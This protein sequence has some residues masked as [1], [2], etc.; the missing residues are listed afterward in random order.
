MYIVKI[1]N[2]GIE[3]EIHGRKAKL[4]DGSIVKGINVIDS[5]TFT[6]LPSN[7]GFSLINDYKTLVSVYNTRKK[8][9]EYFGRV[10]CSTPEM[11]SSGHITKN[12]VCESYFGFL[13]DS[14]QRYVAERNWT[15][16]ELWE[17][18][19]SVHN[20]QVEPERNFQLGEITVEDTND[21]LY[22]GIQRDDTWK[23]I[24]DKLLGKLGG[25]IR[26]R[27]V[28]GLIYIDHLVEIGERRATKIALSR[29]M[30]S[31]RK[32]NDPSAYIS[33]LIPLGA[34]FKDEDGNEREERLDIT[35]VNNGLDY[36]EDVDAREAYGIRVDYAYFDN[37]TT[38]LI[39]KAK[40]EALL[41]ENNRVKIKYSIT[42]VDLS[43]L[44]LDIDD[45]NVC[46]Y[47]PIV[48]PLLGIDDVARLV[49]KTIDVCDE[50]QST[51]EVGDAF[52]SL[53]DIQAEQTKV[54]LDLS[55]SVGRIESNYVSNNTLLTES[56][57]TSSLISQSE[58]GIMASV[59]ESYTKK[60][61]FEEQT[62]ITKS[63][64]SALSD[65]FNLSFSQIDERVNKVDGDLQ[66]KYNE[67][68]KYFTFDLNGL[69]IGE[70]DSPY[71][72]V[73]DNDD[74]TIWS[75]GIIVQEFKADGNSLIPS[76]TVTK[77]FNLLGLQ[78]AED[79]THINCDY[80]GGV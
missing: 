61:A 56:R 27:V 4:K 68:T 60:S 17:H 11:E 62:R 43:L 36:I 76:L 15:V 20:S 80:V 25:E 30:K 73:I 2:N 26:I 72:I 78:M 40:G 64:M 45:F 29:N 75:G 13:C 67:I 38:P 46:D 8:R 3:T 49:K 71:K 79:E 21:N 16:R 23:T 35:S 28:D 10:L 42:A 24:N 37:V 33:R 77:M 39:L 66:S 34:K 70:V 53:S 58:S 55:N 63:E 47:Y 1:Y 19:I 57:K 74:F 52:K 69:T 12:V 41:R 5:F 65:S 22:L 14:K 32:E 48:N 54:M 59:E 50:T 6:M 7:P 44:G 31:I 9:H 51:I 18:V